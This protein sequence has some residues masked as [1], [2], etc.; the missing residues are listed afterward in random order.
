M[1][2]K[3]EEKLSESRYESNDSEPHGRLTCQYVLN[4]K[5]SLMTRESSGQYIIVAQESVSDYLL[6][7]F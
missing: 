6:A 7:L 5:L 4:T 3:P 1:D 2:K